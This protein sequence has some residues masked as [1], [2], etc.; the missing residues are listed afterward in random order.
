MTCSRCRRRVRLPELSRAIPSS[1]EVSCA[2]VKLPDKP[3]LPPRDSARASAM[4]HASPRPRPST[5][6]PRLYKAVPSALI[7]TTSLPSLPYS[8]PTFQSIAGVSPHLQSPPWPPPTSA[9]IPA[10]HSSSL[11][12]STTRRPSSCRRT[13]PPT[14]FVAGVAVAVCPKNSRRSLASS[15]VSRRGCSLPRRLLFIWTSAPSPPESAGDG[16]SC[17]GHHRRRAPC[18]SSVPCGGTGEEEDD[19][20]QAGPS[21]PPT[22]QVSRRSPVQS[23][24]WRRIS[25]NTSFRLES[26]F[27][28]KARSVLQ[29]GTYL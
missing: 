28:Q 7:R 10:S 3:P 18:S 13:S 5:A 4:A 23:A 8:S 16:R 15:T 11:H 20:G 2:P 9:R 22:P 25:G 21:S 17:P 12:S 19:R 26:V 27:L 6:S 29:P 1:P 24:K 14:R